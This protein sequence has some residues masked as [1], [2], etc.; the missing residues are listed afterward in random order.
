[1]RR[2]YAVL[3]VGT[4]L[5][6]AVVVALS[7]VRPGVWATPATMRVEDFGAYWTG[8]LVNLRGGDAYDAANL[9]ELQH[10]IEPE[11]PVPVPAWSPPWTFSA[12]APFTA[13]DFATA[14]WVWRFF[15]VGTLLLAVTATWRAYGGPPDKLVWGWCAALAWYPTLQMIGLGQH[16][17]LVLL[18]VAGGLAL[19]VAGY[20]AAAGAALALILVKPQN[21]YLLAVVAAVW[22][23][24]RR[25][26]RP[27][28]GGLIAATILTA[29][30]I[31][32]NPDVF[33]QYFDALAHRPPAD[34]IPPT[35]GM[36]L[37]FLLG[38]DRFWL[39][40][41]PPVLGLVWGLWYYARN[42][43]RWDWAERVPVV[44]FVSCLTSPYGWMYDQVLFLIPITQLLAVAAAGR[45]EK[46]RSILGVVA[47]LS[48][49]CF[50]QHAAGYREVTFLWHAPVVFVLYLIGRGMLTNPIPQTVP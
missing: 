13:L 9:A 6:V 28:A 49:A 20:S 24:D 31:I 21:L 46:A 4:T 23:V 37:R 50:A 35:P 39:S 19:Y 11:R 7:S 8:T 40:F 43:N 42:R 26:W 30:A 17:N 29:G 25:Q 38:E 45:P 36:A 16:S 41:L 14:R 15:Q 1:M 34:N 47:G 33:G 27:V 3:L 48:L 10:Q 32:P 22:A 5:T 44:L 18:G 12:L 2:P